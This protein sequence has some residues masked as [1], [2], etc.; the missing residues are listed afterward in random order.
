MWC[1]IL[2]TAVATNKDDIVRTAM[3]KVV[4]AYHSPKDVNANAIEAEEMKDARKLVT[5]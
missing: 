3:K 5:A 2:R 4:P 1:Y